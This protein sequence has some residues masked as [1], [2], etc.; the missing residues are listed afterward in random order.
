MSVNKASVLWALAIRTRNFLLPEW[1]DWQKRRGLS[2][3]VPST[4]TCVRSSM[5]LSRVLNAEG[6][7]ATWVNNI[8]RLSEDAP[9]LGPYGYFTGT[10]WEAHAW[11]MYD[12]WIVDITADQF[13]GDEVTITGLE[14][15]LYGLSGVDTAP[16]ETKV[17]RE[18][19]IDALWLRWH[20]IGNK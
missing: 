4:W 12:G 5:F 9:E 3:P 10:R 13:G 20:L 18:A 8:P 11:V 19:E 16:D 7:D 14:N 17:S 2:P 6:Y 1:A 15:P